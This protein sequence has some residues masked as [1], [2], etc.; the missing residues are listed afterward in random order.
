MI[1]TKKC[2][3]QVF[4]TG[5]FTGH[6]CGFAASVERDGK[7]YCKRHDPVEVK[8]QT[9]ERHARWHAKW[10]AQDRE[11]ERQKEIQEAKDRVIREAKTF[12]SWNVSVRALTSA[13]NH[14]LLLESSVRPPV[15]NPSPDL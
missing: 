6:R 1:T 5:S 14:L 9:D 11:R 4:G 7:W 3:R 8:R 10:D 12:T 13:V 2:S 15:D